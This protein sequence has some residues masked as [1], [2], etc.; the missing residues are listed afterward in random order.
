MNKLF[1]YYSNTGNGELVA[2][3]LEAKGYEIRKVT[4]KKDLPKIMFFKILTG[5]FLA[6]LNKKME[7]V[8]FND[9]ITDYDEII[10][11][12]PIWNDRLSCPINTVLAKLNFENKKV[13]FILYAGG[14][15]ATKALAQ[16][17]EYVKD[18]EIVFLKEP[19]KYEEE[20]EKVNKIVG[21]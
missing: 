20:L 12:S 5:G 4:P 9:D 19:K 2:K 16:I 3:V 7:L 11:G 13:K 15:K 21:E 8:N 1:I 10:I 14:G 6:G 17:E 18:K